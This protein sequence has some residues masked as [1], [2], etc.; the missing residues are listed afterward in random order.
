[1]ETGVVNINLP[2]CST[3]QPCMSTV[4]SNWFGGTIPTGGVAT[5]V[6]AVASKCEG[7]TG[8]TPMLMVGGATDGCCVP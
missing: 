1:M 2:I 8:G 3:D 5:A 7:F 6:T 4:D